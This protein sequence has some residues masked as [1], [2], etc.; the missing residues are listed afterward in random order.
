ML[1]RIHSFVLVG[2][3]AILCE[4]EVDVMK[5]GLERTVMVGLPQAA[6]KESIER[7][8]RAIT[9]S[10][11]PFASPNLLINLAPADVKKEGPSLDLPIAIGLLCASGCVQTDLHKSFLMAGE[12]ALD[13]RVRKIKGALSMALLAR[14]KS[15]RGVILPEDNAREAAVVDGIEVYPVSSLA[16][17][18][19]FL[20]GQLP[21]DA[22][23]LDGQVYEAS[24]IAPAADFADVRG[25]EAVKRAIVIAAAGAHNLLMVGPPGTGKTMLAQRLAGILPPL[26]RQESLETTR[27]YSALGLLPDGVALMDQ[28]PVR[29]PHHSAT[30]QALIGGG[31][32]PRPGEV[33]LAHNGILFLDELPEFSRYVLETLRQPLESG[34]VAIARVHG[35]IRFPAR[36]MLVAAMNPS[37]SGYSTAEHGR[38]DKYL[39]KLSG[40]L[41][42]RIDIHVEVPAVTY[43][44]LTAQRSGTD[45]QT[46][47]RQ[48]LAAREIQQARFN[49][50]NY[51]AAMDSRQLKQFCNLDEGCLLL[52]KQAME[53]LG[54]SARAYD[55]VRRVARTIADLEQ[56]EHIREQHVAEAVQ[57]RLLDRRF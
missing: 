27:I 42:D 48:V 28:R 26:T 49:G 3:D 53:E 24:K 6:V 43:R 11:Y 18:V 36:F 15:M 10:G 9:N 50:R 47:R 20:N 31:S 54:L 2:I 25:Q 37:A 44:E 23:Q 30:A 22:Y 55:K 40:P 33:S 51:N 57:Y 45:S 38:R 14:E 7:V 5:S 21:I 41:L 17:A 34:E 32:V 8:K 39:Q 56:S 4:V 13:G 29:M 35:S 1:A 46:M 19:A 12:L 16:Q 52:M